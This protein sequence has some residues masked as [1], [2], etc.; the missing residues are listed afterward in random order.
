MKIIRLCL[1]FLFLHLS[2]PGFSQL[3]LKGTIWECAQIYQVPVFQVLSTDSVMGITYEGLPYKNHRQQVF[4]WY[5]TPGMLKGNRKLDKNLPAVV[6]VHGG[7]GHAFKEWAVQWAKKGYAAIAMDLRGNGAD[8]K[9]IPNGFEEPDGQTPYFDVSL[10]LQE[11]WMFQAVADVLLAHNLIAGF[12]ETDKNRTAITGISWG[13]VITGTVAGLDSRYKAA[14]PVYGCGFL[15]ESGRME[16]ELFKLPEAERKRWMKQYD[17]SAYIKQCNYPVLF[18]D[19]ANDV[20]FYLPS[21]T[22]TCNLAPQ[23]EMCIKPGLKHSHRWGWDSKEIFAFISNKLNGSAPLP[24]FGKI[25]INKKVIEARISS[26]VPL[27]QAYIYFTTDTAKMMENRKWQSQNIVI[28]GNSLFCELPPD[29]TTTWFL[30]VTDQREFIK[31]TGIFIA[32][33]SANNSRISGP[34]KP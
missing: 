2:L 21:L 3:N 8:K 18:V 19:G 10:P 20:H 4:A 15:D 12:P 27:K 13:G 9:H 7:G 32:P 5:A 25:E 16:T 17:P 29:N 26:Q 34:Y 1:V 14:V 28:K 30:S 31:T 11:Q 22:K 33:G 24:V 23:G 6:L